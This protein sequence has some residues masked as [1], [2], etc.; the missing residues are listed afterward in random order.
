[1]MNCLISL[2]DEFS[3]LFQRL[4]TTVQMGLEEDLDNAFSFEICT[5]PPALVDKDGM[6]RSANKPQLANAIWE[7][8]SHKEIVLPEYIRYFKWR[9]TFT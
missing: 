9:L 1:M 3:L 4:I 7:L 2:E 6:L 8:T 5:V